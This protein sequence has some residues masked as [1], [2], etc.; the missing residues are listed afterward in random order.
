LLEG[1]E[2]NRIILD[3]D[4]RDFLDYQQRPDGTVEIVD[5][6]V[7]SERRKG[8]GRRLVEALFS[9]LGKDTRVWAITRA[10]NEIAQQWYEALQFNV[11]GVLRRYYGPHRGVDGVM[12]GRRAGGPV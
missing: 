3:N 11:V 8:K 2:L 10:D 12:F 9:R 5:I 6:A 7:N 1:E 4:P